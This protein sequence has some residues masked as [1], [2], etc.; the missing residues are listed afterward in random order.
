MQWSTPGVG[1]FGFGGVLFGVVLILIGL[2][3]FA[4]PELL[5]YV[6]ASVFVIGG[7][8]VIATAWGLGRRVTYRRMDEPGGE[9]ERGPFPF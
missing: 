1:G 4:M 2:L 3:L 8:G 5:A 9:D 7:V 6:V